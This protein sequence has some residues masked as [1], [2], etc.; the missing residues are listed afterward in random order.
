LDFRKVKLHRLGYKLLITEAMQYFRPA[1]ILDS[2]KNQSVTRSYSGI[3][4]GLFVC[5]L[6]LMH[7]LCYNIFLFISNFIMQ[8]LFYYP[9]IAPQQ[10]PQFPAT[11]NPTGT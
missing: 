3:W 9:F 11:F 5:L 7:L 10:M 8:Y 6:G 4:V 1:M 2:E